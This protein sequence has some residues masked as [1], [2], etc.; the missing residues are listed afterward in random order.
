LRF[1]LYWSWLMKFTKYV[2]SATIRK[3]ISRWSDTLMRSLTG[4]RWS[5]SSHET[6]SPRLV[7]RP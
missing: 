2:A 1:W 5:Y 7:F 3:G 4:V 6:L